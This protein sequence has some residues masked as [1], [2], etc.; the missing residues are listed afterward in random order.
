MERF[1]DDFAQPEFISD[2]QSFFDDY[3]DL[4][5][6]GYDPREA[7]MRVFGSDYYPSPEMGYKRTSDIEASDYYRTT[8][9]E[10][11]RAANPDDLWNVKTSIHEMLSIVRSFMVKDSVR[12]NAIKEL[13]VLCAI[14]I[15][16][17]KGNTK[18]GRSLA[19]FYASE[20][21]K[22]DTPAT[23]SPTKPA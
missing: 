13:N 17:E 14:T 18:A 19:D 11:L 3:I 20:A 4:R 7:F 9:N 23:P 10:K 16:D 6:Q 12:L 15:V 21:A 22:T 8:F 5:I 2:N 1:I